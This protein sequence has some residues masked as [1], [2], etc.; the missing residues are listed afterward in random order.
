MLA[1]ET[2]AEDGLGAGRGD[3]DT[4]RMFKALIGRSR[5]RQEKGGEGDVM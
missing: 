4:S 1:E 2:Q 3:T 5:Q